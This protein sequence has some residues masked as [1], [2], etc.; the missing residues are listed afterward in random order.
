MKAILPAIK[1]LSCCGLIALSSCAT[2]TGDPSVYQAKRE[3]QGRKK[4]ETKN[5]YTQGIVG[6]AILGSLVGGVIGAHNDHALEG[7]LIGGA[8]GAGGGALYADH[9]VKQR[10]QYAGREYNLQV[11]IKNASSTREAARKFNDVLASKVTTARADRASL[12]GT[13]ASSR[14][15]MNGLDQELATQRQA[16]KDARAANLGSAD[17]SRLSSEINGLQTQRNR[18]QDNIEKL[19]PPAPPL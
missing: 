7:A 4:F 8:A 14:D 3:F 12:D 17:R 10:E 6:G 15:V 16:L 1:A 11:A 18:L 5:T 19:T 2:T 9:K 13:L